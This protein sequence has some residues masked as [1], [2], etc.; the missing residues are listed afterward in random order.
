[1]ST[2][3]T[4]IRIALEE[5]TRAG[6]LRGGS[7]PVLLDVGDRDDCAVVQV[8]A[9]LDLVIGT[10]FVRGTGFYLFAEGVLSHGD[11]GWYLVAANLSDIAAMGADP[12]GIV[13]ATRYSKEMTDEQWRALLRGICE[14]CK[15]HGVPLLG[16][17]S[18]GYSADVLSAG[19]IGTVP[20]GRALLRSGGVAGDRL[21]ITGTVGAAGAAV[22]YFYRGRHQGVRLR[23]E[24]EERLRDSWRRV[25]PA[26][27]QGQWLVKNGAS[28]CA[29]D[30]SDGLKA[31]LSEI[32]ARSGVDVVLV[33]AAVPVDPAAQAV[34]EA[35]RLSVLDVA[36]SD[37]V[38]FRLLF[39]VPD[40]TAPVVEAGFQEN[41]WELY[42]IGY[43][44]K[45]NGMPRVVAVGGQRDEEIPGIA[46]DQSDDATVDRLSRR[47]EGD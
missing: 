31:G 23:Q 18:G 47:R 14:A 17:D 9:E 3:E 40:A 28:R 42:Q 11:V 7:L 13:V 12:A 32:S 10:D 15:Y 6:V 1:M 22:A 2:E 8:S 4:R 45:A 24:T 35:M 21:Y 25:M 41:G 43:L 33:P 16:G 26:I 39:S 37:S 5:V 38:D 20:H 29:L 19:A 44:R 27:K 36:L 46:W 34:A 30:T